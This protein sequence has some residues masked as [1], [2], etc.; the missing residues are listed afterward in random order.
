MAITLGQF[1]T[2][3]MDEF[4]LS[5]D[6]DNAGTSSTAVLDYINKAHENFINKKAWKFNIKLYTTYFVPDTTV[7]NAFT[8][9]GGATTSVTLSNTSTWPSTGKI[10]IDGDIIDY[11][12]NSSN[13]LTCTTSSIDRNHSAG[14]KVYFLHKMPTDFSK[15][16]QLFIGDICYFPED[17]RAEKSP[18]PE[19][20]WQHLL[21]TS[22]GELETYIQ[23]PFN[24]TQ[25][26]G[27]LKYSK[28]ATDLT[29]QDESTYV[30]QIPIPNYYD[31]IK[32]SVFSRLYDHQEEQDMSIKYFKRAEIE[33]K[34]ATS[35]DSK[36]HNSINVP[37]RS[38]WDNPKSLLYR[39][40]HNR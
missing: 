28:V 26:T 21:V 37:I 9:T 10:V 3:L 33:L 17:L 4:G 2:K 23:L 20:Y 25:R 12:A 35:F 5:E 13:I 16:A 24:A 40:S 18:N 22:N 36:Q 11:T 15:M 19:R 30:L 27:Y 14:E 32:Y 31:F 6:N 39:N 29:A 38:T 34:L 8:N 7:V 1:R